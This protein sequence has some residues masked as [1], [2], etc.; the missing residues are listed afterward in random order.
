MLPGHGHSVLSK[1]HAGSSEWKQSSTVWF[2]EE[3]RGPVTRHLQL[4]WLK[5]MK[6]PFSTILWNGLEKKKSKGLLQAEVLWGFAKVLRAIWKVEM[7][8]LVK[9]CLNFNKKSNWQRLWW[10]VFFRRKVLTC[11]SCVNAPRHLKG[12]VTFGGKHLWCSQLVVVRWSQSCAVEKWMVA[13]TCCIAIQG[14]GTSWQRG[15]SNC[16]MLRLAKVCLVFSLPFRQFWQQV[17]REEEAHCSKIK[18]TCAEWVAVI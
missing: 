15:V 6:E 3:N 4:E 7:V 5:W 9:S 14:P 16:W 12:W 18:E 17:L 1:L 2:L 11:S 13:F 10:I 8:E